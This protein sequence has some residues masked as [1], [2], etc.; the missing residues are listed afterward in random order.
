MSHSSLSVFSLDLFHFTFSFFISFQ[1]VVFHLS[2]L[3]SLLHL[4]F[5][6][7]MLV[8]ICLR[9]NFLS[10]F[11]TEFHRFSLQTAKLSPPS[12]YIYLTF[13]H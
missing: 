4:C 10:Q 8:S 11:L 1:L 7:V 12:V 13:S 6:F 3:S 2:F 9:L 5:L